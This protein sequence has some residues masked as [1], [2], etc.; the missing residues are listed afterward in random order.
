MNKKE[1]IKKYT[2]SHKYFS[3]SQIVKETNLNKKILKDYLSIFK[4]EKRVFSAGQ[5][6]YSS[7]KE[8]FELVED[9]RTYTLLKH[10]KKNFPYTDFLIWNTR[11][12]QSLYHHTQLHHITFI[13]VEKD[14]ILPFYEKISK[15]YIET[16]IEKRSRA[17]YN[18][19]NIKLNPVVIR[20]LVS[21]SLKPKN[22]HIPQAE[23]VLVDLFMDVDKYKYISSSDYWKVWEELYPRYRIDIGF[24][25]NYAKRRGCLESIFQPIISLSRKYE[26]DFCQLLQ[27]SGKSL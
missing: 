8:T 19:F 22:N 1:V 2:E 21:R 20:R 7:I 6:I 17:Y 12:L 27:E 5:G 15:E 10:L 23:K 24:V 4:K 11:Q 18:S 16:V 14:A 9:S 25:Y 13:D 26:I 3:L